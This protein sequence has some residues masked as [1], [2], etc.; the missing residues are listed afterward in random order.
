MELEQQQEQEKE[1]QKERDHLPAQ[2]EEQ[3]QD[4]DLAKAKLEIKHP[5]LTQPLSE[6]FM[7][8][9]GVPSHSFI[10]RCTGLVESS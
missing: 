6:F 4:Q 2:E 8:V 1:T 10:L 5:L 3:E 9:W 7:G